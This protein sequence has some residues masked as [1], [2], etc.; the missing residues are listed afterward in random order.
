MGTHLTAF[1]PQPQHVPPPPPLFPSSTP[2]NHTRPLYY[3]APLPLSGPPPPRTV[4]ISPF[5]NPG[6]ID[7]NIRS[8]PA[9]A[10]CPQE[11]A[12]ARR[13]TWK[14][15]CATSPPLPFMVLRVSGC[16]NTVTVLPGTPD[17]A[18][19]TIGDVLDAVFR[20]PKCALSAGLECDCP[21]CIKF[22]NRPRHARSQSDTAGTPSGSVLLTDDRTPHPHYQPAIPQ[23]GIEKWRWLGLVASTA[24]CEVWT[25]LLD[26]RRGLGRVA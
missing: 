18:F 16:C 11:R 7:W 5:L 4:R 13:N 9:T 15:E 23:G 10:S 22:D 20:A 6:Q 3:A 25:L 8:P 19:V 17:R 14:Q 1:A 2:P 21:G 12:S 24:E 26:A